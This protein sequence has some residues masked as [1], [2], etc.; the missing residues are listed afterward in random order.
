MSCHCRTF[1]IY[2]AHFTDKISG[3]R[4]E[5]NV[6]SVDI[7]FTQSCQCSY[8]Q[9][10]TKIVQQSTNQRRVLF[11]VNQSEK[12]IQSEFNGEDARSKRDHGDPVMSEKVYEG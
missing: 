1:R 6:K 12:I 11:C 7:I 5:N 4:E 10:L 2:L 3:V 9:I 8:L